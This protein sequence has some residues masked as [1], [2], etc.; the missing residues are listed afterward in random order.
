MMEYVLSPPS[1]ITSD[2]SF[3]GAFVPLFA[4]IGLLAIKERLFELPETIWY[5]Y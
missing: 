1:G 2:G 4:A 5:R 3:F